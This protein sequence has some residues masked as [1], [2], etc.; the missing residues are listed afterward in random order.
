MSIPVIIN[1]RDLLTWPKAMVE[2]ISRYEG[3]GDIIIVD[4][5]SSYSPLLEW[6]NTNPCKIVRCSNLGHAGA[7]IS[8]T[9]AKLGSSVYVVTDGDLGLDDTPDNTLLHLKD[10]LT[11]ISPDKVGLGLNW[12]IVEEKSPY[13]NRLNLYEKGRWESSRVINNVYMDVAIDTTFAMYNSSL[14][15]IG[16]ASTPSPYIARHYPWELSIEEI[17]SNPEFKYYLDRASHSCSYKKVVP[18]I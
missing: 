17:R 18:N 11:T 7:W 16:G 8:G 4:N 2:R 5:D 15:F 1:N 12:E 13:Y 6:Y 9:V 3:V 10:I 14:Y